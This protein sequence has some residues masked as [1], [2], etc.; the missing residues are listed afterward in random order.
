MKLP[1][2]RDSSN[3]TIDDELF[4]TQSD[5]ICFALGQIKEIGKRIKTKKKKD[6]K[7]WEKENNNI[8]TSYENKSKRLI[9]EKKEKK[10]QTNSLDWKRHNNLFN[11]LEISNIEASEKIK[12]QV[13]IKYDTK[14]KYKDKYQ[15]L[16]DFISTKNDTFLANTMI[17]ILNDK[18]NNMIKKQGKYSKS[19]RHEILLLDKDINK[20]DDFVIT[21]EKKRKEDEA[22]LTKRIIENKNLVE[23]YKKTLQD[24]NSTLY[25]IFRIL[26]DMNE[27]KIYAKFIHKLLG[28]DNDILHT[29]LIGNINFKDFKNYDVYSITQKILK[30][31]KTLMN[32]KEHTDYEREIYNFDLSFKDMEDKLIKLFFKIFEF[33]SEINDTK[34]EWKIIEQTKQKKYDELNSI[35]EKLLIELKESINEYNKLSFNQEEEENI[36]FNYKLLI[37]IFSFLFPKAEVIKNIKDLKVENAYDLKSDVASPIASEINKLENRVNDLINTM[38]ECS[39]EDFKLFEGIL[40]KRKNE[41]RALRLLY[42][43]NIIKKKEELKIKKYGIKMR[44]IIIKDRHKYDIQIPNKNT[45]LKINKRIKTDANLNEYNYLYF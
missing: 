17:Q 4:L 19:L 39:K 22:S 26:K 3:L 2:I 29:E 12:K 13:K 7:I 9:K 30:K 35:Y 10:N 32:S 21:L 6:L 15:T 5:D 20:F 25:E 14:Y 31:T 37:D 38:E 28:G 18:K 16:S 41:N 40:V 36:K 45:K 34:K 23:L 24:Y 42:E 44:K 11:Q 1:K 8:Y 43:K 27:Y 33:E